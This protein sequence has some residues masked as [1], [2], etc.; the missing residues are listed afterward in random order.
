MTTRHRARR[1]FLPAGGLIVVLLGLA[2][3]STACTHW[4]RPPMGPDASYG[5][6]VLGP[7]AL[8]R[9][10]LVEGDTLPELQLSQ[11]PYVV[12]VA[13]AREAETGRFDPTCTRYFG[14]SS[15]YLTL[16]VPRCRPGD[17]LDESLG[18]A[19]FRRNGTPVAPALFHVGDEYTALWPTSRLPARD[20]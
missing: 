11:I 2:A 4:T 17:S 10:G 5:Y 9:F 6:I 8:R 7:G 19:V 15:T 14:R 12:T 1:L 3:A 13:S 20:R 18:M 16:L